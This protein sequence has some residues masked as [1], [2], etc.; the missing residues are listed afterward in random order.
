MTAGTFPVIVR[1]NAVIPLPSALTKECSCDQ[2]LI[3]RVHDLL[4][5]AKLVGIVSSTYVTE[6]VKMSD[7]VASG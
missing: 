6:E 1:R 3:S 5:K 7:T 2:M 4:H